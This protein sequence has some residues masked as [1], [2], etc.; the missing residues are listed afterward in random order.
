MMRFKHNQGASMVEFVVIIVWLAI[1]VHV[2]VF[3]DGGV[4]DN[5]EEHERRYIQAISAP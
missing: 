3:E 5:L 2:A 4:I 1:V